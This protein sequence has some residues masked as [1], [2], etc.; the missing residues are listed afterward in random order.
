MQVEFEFAAL[1]LLHVPASHAVQFDI[2]VANTASLQ[3]PRGQ[4]FAVPLDDPDGQ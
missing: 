2:D 1:T 3:V 4:G